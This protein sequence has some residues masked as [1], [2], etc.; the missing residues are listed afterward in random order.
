L[1][2]VDDDVVDLTNLQR[3]IAHTVDRIGQA[4]VRSAA[5]AVA[6]INP[7]VQVEAIAE[8][9]DATLLDSLVARA[10][11]VLDCCD[12][13]ATRQAVNAA[14]VRHRVPLVSGAA[15]RVD[16][17][18]AVFDSR[19][20]ESPCYACLF[21]P[22]SAPEETRCA[23]LGVLAPLVGMISAAAD[24]H[25][26][27]ALDWPPADGQ[28]P[29]HGVRPAWRGAQPPVPSVWALTVRRSLN[30]S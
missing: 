17:Q 11:V 28:C 30:T 20:A 15:V 13:F 1:I 24:L 8:R 16:A 27:R 4:K 22:D 9:A 2:L 12:N 23:T 29:V 5:A 19:V 3:Q 7:G 26:Q 25:W 10:D 21:P 14:C 18:L 6:A